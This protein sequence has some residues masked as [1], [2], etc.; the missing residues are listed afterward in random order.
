MASAPAEF[1]LPD[2]IRPCVG[3]ALGGG[4]ARGWAHIGVIRELEA[5]GI[6]VHLVAGTSIGA[7]VGAI[8][9]GGQ[10]GEFEAWVTGLTRK[11]VFSLMDFQFGG[12]VL[13]GSRLMDFF[14]TRFHDRDIQDLG[15]PFAATAT[16]LHTGAEVWLRSGSTLDAVRA[17]IAL[18]GLFTPVL[19]GGR[20]LVDG[21]LVNPVPVSL[22]RAMEADVVIAVD[23]ASELPARGAPQGATDAATD[24]AGWPSMMAVIASSIDIMQIRIS[25]SRMAGDPPDAIIRPRVAHIGILDFHRAPEAIEAGRQAVRE[26]LPALRP[27]LGLDAPDA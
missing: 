5:L 27:R 13:K 10:L 11:T 6:E 9:A 7:L 23:L 18:P 1:P 26:A 8:H 16:A 3:L 19:Y 24:A 4:S 12:G 22:A 21:G 17:S 2:R 14:R 15:L 20:L 25:R